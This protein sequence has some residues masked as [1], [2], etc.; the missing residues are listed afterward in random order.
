MRCF[1][2]FMYK[3]KRSIFIFF[4]LLWGISACVDEAKYETTGSWNYER[5]YFEFEYPADTI[6]FGMGNNVMCM[7]AK[8]IKGMVYGIAA[9]KMQDYFAGIDFY[10]PDSLI[11]RIRTAVGY[12]LGLH[13]CYRRDDQFLEITPDPRDLEA[14]MGQGAAVIPPISFRCEE[15]D[16]QMRL[17]LEEVYIQSIF[18]NTEIQKMIMP[19]LARQF[20]PAFDM[21][22]EKARQAML[23]GIQ[24]QL[25]ELID[26]I[27]ML[28]IGFILAR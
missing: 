10:A 2:F 18:E 25:S 15:N 28:K 27:G 24:K 1:N 23:Q 12:A 8:D 22:P 20:N 16:G 21:M 19:V 9:E 17:Y 5:P 3:M 7:A 11:V 13:F 26:N 14:F 4:V 6:R